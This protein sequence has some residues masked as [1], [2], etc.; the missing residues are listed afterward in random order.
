MTAKEITV[1][2]FA[3]G[4][5]DNGQFIQQSRKPVNSYDPI[6]VGAAMIKGAVVKIEVHKFTSN[7]SFRFYVSPYPHGEYYN[8][9]VIVDSVIRWAKQLPENICPEVD[10]NEKNVVIS[11]KDNEE[12]E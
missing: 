8:R 11:I 3:E 2:M 12:Y 7:D 5:L 1:E 10:I 4:V 9:D 6:I